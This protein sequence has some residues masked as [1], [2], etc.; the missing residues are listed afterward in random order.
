MQIH[1]IT[2]LNENFLKRLATDARNDAFKKATGVDWNTYK[3]AQPQPAPEP[4]PATAAAPPSSR[5]AGAKARAASAARK[6][7]PAAAAVN[8]SS[9]PVVYR[10]DR[11][12]LDPRITGDAEIIKKLQAAGVTS[13][14][15]T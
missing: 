13:A 4:T 12:A 15:S 8:P 6:G 11:R 5:V 9:A 3:L 1:E 2:T 10:F 14:T 7:K